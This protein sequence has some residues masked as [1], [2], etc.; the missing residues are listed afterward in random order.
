ML[1][2]KLSKRYRVHNLDTYNLHLDKQQTNSGQTN[3]FTIF[4]HANTMLLTFDI[5][6]LEL[7]SLGS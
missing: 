4:S 6:L 7:N 5:Y 1:P 3:L 2:L